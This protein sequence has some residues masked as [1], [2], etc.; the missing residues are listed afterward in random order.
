MGRTCGYRL[1]RS[2]TQTPGGSITSHAA[3]A[4][5]PC[6]SAPPVSARPPA[7]PLPSSLA[8]AIPLPLCLGVL[9]GALVVRHLRACGSDVFFLLGDAGGQVITKLFLLPAPLQLQ[10]CWCWCWCCGGGSPTCAP[11]DLLLFFFVTKTYSL[12]IAYCI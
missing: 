10:W 3:A 5:L 12:H 4:A 7:A 8:R 9:V 11:F 1:G 2:K 6:S